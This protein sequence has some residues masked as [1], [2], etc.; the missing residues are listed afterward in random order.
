MI[1]SRRVY[2]VELY[3]YAIDTGQRRGAL[4]ISLTYH[5][6]VAKIKLT[7]KIKLADAARR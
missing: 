6:A 3:M 5:L 4:R 2:N 1:I 7:I